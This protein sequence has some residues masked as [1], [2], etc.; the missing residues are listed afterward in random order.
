MNEGIRKM[1]IA[2]PCMAVA[3]GSLAAWQFAGKTFTDQRTLTRLFGR[4][5]TL[6]AHR[7]YSAKYPQNTL[8]AFIGAA[9]A[10]FDGFHFEIRPTKDGVWVAMF[11]ETADE[12]T[13]GAGKIA[14]LTYEEL[15]KFTID[16]G[17]GI[18][19]YP[20]LKVPT[21]DQALA[22]CDRYDI[23]PMI[24]IKNCNDPLEL[25]DVLRVISAH[26]LEK[27]AVILSADMDWLKLIR[28]LDPEIRMFY[29]A[30]QI[31][32]EEA[33]QCAALGNTGVEVNCKNLFQMKDALKYAEEKGVVCGTW[34]VDY[35]FLADLSHMFGA[36]TIL[37]NRLTHKVRI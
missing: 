11:F 20:G 16:T 30:N 6:I 4:T 32:K 29:L 28:E 13:D 37:T 34:T 26:G 33:D 9:E 2:L 1:L 5:Q 36:D 35:P 14:D 3:I 17:N 18:E 27:K 25:P 19:N 12:M 23:F 15:Q 21:L 10:G 8:A 31:S 7:G 24:E 22:V